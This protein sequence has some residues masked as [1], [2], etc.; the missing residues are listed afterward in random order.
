[1]KFETTKY[2][3]QNFDKRPKFWIIQL[4][5]S[6]PNFGNNNSKEYVRCAKVKTGK[7]KILAGRNLRGGRILRELKD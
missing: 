2:F 1:M 3:V 6:T 5:I 4:S 7:G